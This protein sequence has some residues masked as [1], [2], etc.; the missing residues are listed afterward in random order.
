MVVVINWLTHGGLN[1]AQGASEQKSKF[2]DYKNKTDMIRSNGNG[3]ELCG[4][5][6]TD[7]VM[8][9]IGEK[10]RF[11]RGWKSEG[12]VDGDLQIGVILVTTFPNR[13]C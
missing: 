6:E 4:W 8:E 10:I 12:V 1:L 5:R 3:Q 7:S 9:R 11:M 2:T 13:R